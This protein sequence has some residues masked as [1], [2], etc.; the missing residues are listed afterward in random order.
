MTTI[1]TLKYVVVI[2]FSISIL[3]YGFMI[4]KYNYFPYNQIREV[5]KIVTGESS[6]ASYSNYYH[7]KE[8]FFSSHDNGSVDLIFLGD[9]LTDIGEWNE[10]FPSKKSINRGINGDTTSG[11]ID[12]LGSITSLNPTKIFIMLGVN[13]L[14]QGQTVDN[15]LKNYIF[16]IKNLK[17]RGF[18]VYI[19]STLLANHFNADNSKI[20]KLNNELMAFC[21]ENNIPFIDLNKSLSE[22]GKLRSDLT[23]DGIHLNGKGYD[24]WKNE[25]SNIIDN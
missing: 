17:D 8:S 22:N 3:G 24:I 2:L 13:D 12:R 18:D 19:Q 6:T 1:K 10:V 9:S 25:L 14:M 21:H 4:G 7:N 23:I 15:T 11:V 16:I 20:D 5:K